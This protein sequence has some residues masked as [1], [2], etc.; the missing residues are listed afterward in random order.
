MIVDISSNNGLIDFKQVKLSGVEKVVV[1]ATMGFNTHDKMLITNANSVHAAGIPVLYY[2]FAYEHGDKESASDATIQANYFLDTI[3]QLPV[4]EDLVIDLEPKD[5]AGN[6]TTF[7]QQQFALWLQ[8]FLDVVEHAT[9]KQ[10][11]IYTYADYL[12]R[13]LL[14]NHSFGKYRLWIANYH[15]PTG[16]GTGYNPPLPKGWTKYYMWQYSQTGT[17]PG[18]K[19]HVDLS[20]LHSL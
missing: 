20:K 8:T 7:N 9:G 13:H 14:G 11:I 5:A 1:R 16:T 6:D 17:V 19:T 2:H 3:K 18:I 10:M 12:N 15:S 4:A